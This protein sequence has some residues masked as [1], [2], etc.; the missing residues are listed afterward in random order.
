MVSFGYSL[1]SEDSTP[2]QL[3]EQ[4]ELA[5]RHGFEGLWISDHYHPWTDRQGQSPFVWS[6]LGALSARVALPV[7]TA[8]TCPTVR[9]HPAVV[10]QAAATTAL[11]HEGRFVLGVGSGEALNEHITGAHWPAA[12]VRQDMLAEAVEVMRELWGGGLVNH[13]GT[14]YEVENARLYT[15]PEKPPPVY[16]S[17]FGPRSLELAIRIGDGLVSTKPD[18]DMVRT[19]RERAG[20]DKPTTVGTKACWA[21]T[22]DEAVRLAHDIWGSE[23]LPGQ[24][25]QELPQ[26]LHF[27]QLMSLVTPEMVA[28]VV[29]CGPDP[30]DHIDGLRPFVE[31]G[32]DAVYVANIGPYTEQFCQ[33]YERDVLPALRDLAS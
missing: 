16:V 17:A 20:T 28:S 27:E 32:Y 15:L 11:M 3:L 9:I 13:R 12:E 19:F 22:K 6:V 2:A 25:A 5:E 21:P 8:V 4:A 14:H 1:A 31:A 33:L 10:A 24:A 7:M 18:A 30:Q 29:P 26:P 23:Q